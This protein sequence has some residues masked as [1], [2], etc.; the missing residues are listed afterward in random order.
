MII[1]VLK[2][3]ATVKGDFFEVGRFSDLYHPMVFVKGLLEDMNA[4]DNVPQG[5]LIEYSDDA[6]NEVN[7]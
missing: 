5:I 7:E 3:N 6:G 1:K 4:G 2:E